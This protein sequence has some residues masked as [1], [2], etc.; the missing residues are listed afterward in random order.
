MYI[1]YII[2]IVMIKTGMLDVPKHTKSDSRKY[3]QKWL[4]RQSTQGLLAKVNDTV[5]NSQPTGGIPLS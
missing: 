5:A 1:P 2:I 4:V 3:W